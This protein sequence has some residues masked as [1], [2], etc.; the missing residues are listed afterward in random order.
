MTA[1]RALAARNDLRIG[2]AVDTN[3]LANDA[4]YQRL[5]AEQFNTVT[6]ENVMKWQ[7]VEPQRGQLDFAAADGLV[8]FAQAHGQR[9]RGHTLVWHNQLPG[10]LGTGSFTPDELRAILRRHII[11]EVGH[12]RGRIW[13]W[14]VVNEAFNDDGT[15]RESIW[16]RHLGP[17]YIA[18]AFG[19]ARE[20]D[21]GALLFYNDYNIEGRNPKS[22][23]VYALVQRLRA[24]GVPIDG[25]GLQGHLGVQLG[26]PDD[27]PENM[28]R[29]TALGLRVAVTEADV[30]IPLPTD[31]PK[32]RAQA[33]GYG[34]LLRACLLTAQCLS[35]TVWGFSDRYQWVPG[36]FAGQGSAALYDENFVPKPA[37]RAMQTSLAR[38]ERRA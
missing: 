31:D 27:V 16:L 30:R 20:A 23:A 12:F 11:D 33:E 37:Y 6:P 25:V 18:D 2:T 38:S 9:V 13:Q 14:D 26:F 1:L 10:W 34:V 8:A 19:W 7:L 4:T 28:A 29:F 17:G 21:P 5:V 36:V 32:A 24:E 35:F 15:L 3:A 22:D